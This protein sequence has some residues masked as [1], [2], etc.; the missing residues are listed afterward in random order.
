MVEVGNDGLL[1]RVVII[2]V[3]AG[4]KV[5]ELMPGLDVRLPALVLDLG[6]DLLVRVDLLTLLHLDFCLV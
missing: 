6:E 3:V 4:V 2:E 1:A 5:L